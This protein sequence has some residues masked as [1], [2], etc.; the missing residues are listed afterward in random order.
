VKR[1]AWWPIG[2]ATVLAATVGANIWIAVVAND[3]PS[4]AIE[5]DY[6]KK[7]VA[8]D[9]TLAR[10]EASRRLGWHIEPVLGAM[11][12]DGVQLHVTLVDSTGAPIEGAT[13]KVSA[14][15]NARAGTLVNATLRS[16]ASEYTAQ[17]PVHH[18]GQWELRFDVTRGT[19]RFVST[20]R[21]EAAAAEHG[22]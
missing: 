6:Y 16:G 13:V 7:A 5:Q 9:T 22:L 21:V 17:L 10:R 3:D 4:F 8:W 14:F 20:S 1:G 18:A 2:I 11:T 15:Y 12:R 19:D